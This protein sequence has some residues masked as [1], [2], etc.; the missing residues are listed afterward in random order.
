MVWPVQSSP[1][2]EEAAVAAGM[3]SEA[4]SPNELPSMALAAVL[5][6]TGE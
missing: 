5:D 1:E 3:A 4:L 6:T 2:V